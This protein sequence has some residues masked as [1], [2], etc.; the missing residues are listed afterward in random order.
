LQLLESYYT[1]QA[2]RK[3]KEGSKLSWFAA[4]DLGIV[5]SD[6]LFFIVFHAFAQ[7]V[8][9]ICFRVVEF[10]DAFANAAHEFRDFVTAEQ[11]KNNG[12]NEKH[13]R[14]AEIEY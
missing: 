10:T 9:N 12:E 3:N 1:L 2:L 13:L 8:F 4:F 6:N 11:Q 5:P 14:A 7:F